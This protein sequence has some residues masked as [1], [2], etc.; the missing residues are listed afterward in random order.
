MNNKT[1]DYAEDLELE[2][3]KIISEAWPADK[4]KNIEIIAKEHQEIQSYI[5]DMGSEEILQS[6]YFRQLTQE[7]LDKIKSLHKEW[8]PLS[9]PESW[10]NKIL[11]K[12]RV[13]ALGCF[14]EHNDQEILIGSIISRIQVA[15]PDVIEIHKANEYEKS[16]DDSYFS[17]FLSAFSCKSFMSSHLDDV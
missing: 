13:I 10:Y 6:M 17:R 12:E 5:E 15:K 9:Y 3:R 14:I 7:D 1:S 8:F 4:R 11:K 16:R 2:E